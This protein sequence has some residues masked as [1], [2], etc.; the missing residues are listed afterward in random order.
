MM[1]R[2]KLAGKALADLIREIEKSGA[3]DGRWLSIGKTDLQ[4]GLMAVTRSI[5]TPEFF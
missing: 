1:N 3:A 4:K 2:V 5:A